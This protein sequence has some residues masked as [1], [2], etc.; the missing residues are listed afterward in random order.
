M[1][2]KREQKGGQMIGVRQCGPKQEK[3]LLV[4]DTWWQKAVTAHMQCVLKRG[5]F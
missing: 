2:Q 5:A 1:V 3:Q 4:T